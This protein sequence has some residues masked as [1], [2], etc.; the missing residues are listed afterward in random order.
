MGSFG[1]SICH[2]TQRPTFT[3]TMTTSTTTSE[4]IQSPAS[5]VPGSRKPGGG[6]FTIRCNPIA[7]PHIQSVSTYHSG[8]IK[9]PLGRFRKTVSMLPPCVLMIP[10]NNVRLLLTPNFHWQLKSTWLIVDCHS[11]MHKLRLILPTIR[12]WYKDFKNIVFSSRSERMEG[13]SLCSILK[14]ALHLLT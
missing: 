2:S 8:D 11:P 14:Q 10:D 1:L 13:S 6:L 5:Q 4:V 12:P 7:S 3:I 9:C